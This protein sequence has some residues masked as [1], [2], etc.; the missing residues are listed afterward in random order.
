MIREISVA[1]ALDLPGAVIIDVRSEGEFQEDTIPGAV[2]IPLLDNTGRAL[3]G[4]AYKEKGPLEARRLGLEIV[5]PRLPRWVQAVEKA[6]PGRRVVLFC[7]RGGLRSLFAAYLL[8]VMGFAVYRLAGGYKAYRRYVIQYLERD[9][10][11]KAVVVHG[12]TGVGKT[13]LLQRLAEMGLP[14][15]DLEGL[16]R[17]RG[18]VF[19]KIGLP[20]S[21]RQKMFESLIVRDLRA[22]EKRGLFFVECESRRLGNLLVPRSVL[23][24]M[25]KGYR[26]LLYDSLENRVRR[27]VEEYTCG[28]GQN[29]PALQEATSALARYLGAQQVKE[30]VERLARGEFAEVFAYL[31]VKHYDPL[32][33]YPDAP[34][35]GY[36]L[37]VS[38]ADFEEA[39]RR[40]S[41]WVI[42]LPEYVR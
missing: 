31:L 23:A 20:P 6:A 34:S 13:R 3:V 18:S 35:E 11:M 19:G 30:L 36:D 42:S 37:C 24:S 7:W 2:N 4:T 15:L 38:T 40:V 32:Y 33:R 17:H 9:L 21:P 1:E 39:V 22:A 41:E 16:A 28:P 12:L 25:E 10:P 27:L 29:I 5:S 26:V 8:D 14:V